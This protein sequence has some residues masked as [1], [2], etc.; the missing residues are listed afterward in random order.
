MPEAATLEFRG[1]TKRYPGADHAAVDGL[2]LTVEAGEICV[3]LGPSGCGKTTAMRMVNRMIEMTDG[4]ILLD[5]HS[6]RERNPADLRR[7]IGYAIQQ[8]GLFPHQ[9]VEEN[10]GA[11]P[12]LL[13]RDRAWI[14]NRAAELL[15][16][17]GLDASLAA[18]Y[19]TQLSGG[20]R[21]RVGVARAIAA[22]PPLLLMDEP[23]GAVDPINRGRL[24]TE[25]L[26][27]QEEIRKTVVFVTH[28]IGEAITMGDRI[29]IMREGGHLVQ[30]GTPAEILGAPADDFVREFI[31]DRAL[32]IQSGEDGAL[33]VVDAKG[34]PLGTISQDAVRRAL[35]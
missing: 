17:V 16:L 3:L 21:Q 24:Q 14:R 13:G 26:R 23:F 8:I 7:E 22:N 25:F 28:D 19:P 10:I 33:R 34:R 5:G 27:L 1:A 12:K 15:E 11:V 20:Q 30:Y 29:A 31:G 6:V 32:H 9:T 2:T 4:D 18:R 35:P